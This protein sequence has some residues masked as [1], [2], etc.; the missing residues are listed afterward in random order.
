MPAAEPSHGIIMLNST[1]RM[2]WLRTDGYFG[3]LPHIDGDLLREDSL[4]QLACEWMLS[5][6]S[7]QTWRFSH[8]IAHLIYLLFIYFKNE[9]IVKQYIHH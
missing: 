1:P 6:T 7:E 2:A 9:N 5:T 3:L 4:L 8:G